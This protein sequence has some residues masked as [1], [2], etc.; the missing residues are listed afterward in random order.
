MK[1]F[2]FKKISII[3]LAAALS[4]VPFIWGYLKTGG[5]IFS[6]AKEKS[7]Q[8]QLATPEPSG[9]LPK[10]PEVEKQ[11]SLFEYFRSE[12]PTDTFTVSVNKEKTLIQQ[13]I[14]SGASAAATKVDRIDS[15]E[16]RPAIL[17][18]NIPTPEI[19]IPKNTE[20]KLLDEPGAL[21]LMN[22][23]A[24][25]HLDQDEKRMLKATIRLSNPIEK[26]FHGR[27][28]IGLPNGVRSIS[29]TEVDVEIKG[30]EA[31][32]VPVRLLA[33]DMRDLG[34]GNEIAYT[35]K[36][37]YGREVS[38]GKTR[39]GFTERINLQLTVDQP[40]LS[41]FQLN[42]SLTL[43]ARV[44]NRGNVDQMVLVVMSMQINNSERRFFELKGNVTAGGNRLFEMKIW[45]R[46]E[47]F[48]NG[49]LRVNISG[50]RG[51][52]KQVFGNALLTV[53]SVVSSRKFIDNDLYSINLLDNQTIPNDITL[54]YRSF[55]GNNIYQIMGGGHMNLPAGNLALQ[56]LIYKSASQSEWIGLNT[57][58]TY[59]YNNASIALGNINEQLEYSLMGRGLKTVL[60][61]ASR[62]NTLK[63]G[64]VDNQ[65]NLFSQR[66]LFENGYSFYVKGEL[67][68]PTAVTKTDVSY[69]FRDDA[70]ERAKHHMAGA[71]QR[72]QK[73]NNWRLLVKSYGGISS[74]Y[75][76]GK[77]SPSGAAEM[78]YSGQIA[79]GTQ[80]AG[81]FYHSTRYFPGNRRGLTSLQQSAGKNLG[82]A[83]MLRANAF[84]TRVAPRSHQYNL[85]ME[86]ETARLDLDYSTHKSGGL[87]LGLGYQRQ[88]EYGNYNYLG[89]IDE[90]NAGDRAVTNAHRLIEYLNWTSPNS[91]YT[92]HTG[93]ENG[94]VQNIYS[95]KWTPQFRV[96]T[97]LNLG[98][99]SLNGTYQYGGYFLSEQR[100][101]QQ[102]GRTT[103]RFILSSFVR[104]NLFRNKLS[105]GAGGNYT[106]DFALGNTSSAFLNLKHQLTGNYSV[107]VNNMVYNYA[108]STDASVNT[109][110]RTF[111]NVEAGLQISMD[112]IKP[113]T[114]KKSRILISAFYDI[115]GNRMMDEGE[116]PAPDYLIE[117]DGKAFLTDGAGKVMYS[118]VPFGVYKIPA[119]AG[120]GW[121]ND[122]FVF[123]V[124][125]FKENISMPLHQAGTVRG[126]VE[127]AYNKV[128][129]REFLPR[130][131]GISFRITR[132]GEQVDEVVSN[133]EGNFLAFLPSGEYTI[134]IEE[135]MMDEN[136][137]V[138]K[139][140]QQF[141]VQSG[142]I[143]TLET[144]VLQ[145]KNKQINIRK[146]IQ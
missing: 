106:K 81:N 44:I 108:Y 18:V 29:A 56:G 123:Q 5:E 17:P 11:D 1:P 60:S 48:Q 92:I 13:E 35:L 66:N 112:K 57:R 118:S 82:T 41:V 51:Y 110:N 125:D 107:F 131:S 78:Q 120:S 138:L 33:T 145:V 134:E 68:E 28:T 142:K 65:F 77:T 97:S 83:S 43:S 121:F 24:P 15:A 50:M 4:S 103:Q 109:Y 105:V 111:Y 122:E 143:T 16:M 45:P 74:Y 70:W 130:Q 10:R 49:S 36:D 104:K 146:F 9:S 19:E 2:R 91:K 115:N 116:L 75:E 71:E 27:L 80:L 132:K 3:T 52:E 76:A 30:G 54:S 100:F 137:V 141:T 64:V 67:G 38:S 69:L 32:F 89:T 129:A 20:I 94:M 34:A 12:S 135:N 119:A 55:A 136:V 7:K 95:K 72:W 63:I 128:K 133:N 59:Q 40:V 73:G 46:A 25:E 101:A 84:Y 39:I 6:Y 144:F 96:N 127:Y 124:D 113:I 98:S 14:T 139:P 79:D 90:Q 88:F 87:A 31:L 26:D 93:I 58:L 22:L 140:T 42:D 61:D 37:E 102:M 117:L 86:T 126:Q 114:G 62:K 53:Q 99:V 47:M 21:H 8:E 85:E 23:E